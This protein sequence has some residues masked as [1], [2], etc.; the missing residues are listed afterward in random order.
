MEPVG[1]PA[2]VLLLVLLV[3][4]F[5]A[6]FRPYWAFL[7]V[8]VLFSVPMV[9]D[10]VN[11]RTAF[12]GP[13]FNLYDA[14]FVV[15]LLALIM[16]PRSRPLAL[17]R[18]VAWVLLVIALGVFQTSLDYEINTIVIRAI[19][20]SI[21][22]PLACVL[23]AN[24]VVDRSRAR[25]F[26]FALI[27][28]SVIAAIRSFLD[29]Q[30]VT[31]AEQ[32]VGAFRLNTASASVGVS[33]LV[34]ATHQSFFPRGSWLTKTFWGAA[35]ILFGMVVLFGQW[36]AVY[37]SILFSVMALPFILNRWQKMGRTALISLVGL[38]LILL[39]IHLT[40][41]TVN[42]MGFFQRL[43]PYLNYKEFREKP[44]PEDESRIRQINREFEEWSKG[45]WLWG[46]GLSFIVFLPDG[47][48]RRI[49]WGHIGYISYLSNL[50]LLGLFFMGIYLPV[51]IFQAAKFLNDKEPQDPVGLLGLT[52][53]ATVLL[54]SI[55]SFMSTSYLSPNTHTVGFLYG[56]I[57][58]LAYGKS[59]AYNL[60]TADATYKNYPKKLMPG[61][62]SL[63]PHPSLNKFSGRKCKP[64]LH[65]PWKKQNIDHYPT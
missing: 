23:G 54:I 44:R 62:T 24:L 3:G 64:Q 35:L 13:Y 15:A 47:M 30:T 38:P 10:A 59:S 50:G 2:Y 57:W 39:T 41:P 58:T 19:R 12:L 27:V 56:A 29:Y 1:Y 18:P 33:F 21:T 43:T 31:L 55:M 48:D 14:L 22:F 60:I 16:D 49:A 42:P 8:V 45:N 32:G 40:L 51:R 6:L 28:A 36:R 4:G 26:L 20:W 17:P 65:A 53:I 52:A 11:T 34:A 7:F 9:Y 46:R 25:L 37:L 63:K 61:K 5:L